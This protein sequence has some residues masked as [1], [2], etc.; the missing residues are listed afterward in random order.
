MA[1]T[2][3]S[4][5]QVLRKL[6][7]YSNTALNTTLTINHLS[8]LT[9]TGRARGQYTVCFFLL[10]MNSFKRNQACLLTPRHT[11]KLLKEQPHK[12]QNQHAVNM[13]QERLVIQH[14]IQ[15][16]CSKT[17]EDLKNIYP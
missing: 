3:H 5:K 11:L 6:L 13:P 17:S 14:K 1:Q 8:E 15:K 2:Y 16:A 7:I 12:R 9:G 10:S 4:L